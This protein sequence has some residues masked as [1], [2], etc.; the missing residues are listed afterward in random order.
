V[1]RRQIVSPEDILAAEIE[2]ALAVRRERP[3]VLGLCGAQGSG[4]STVAKALTRRFPRAVALSL[5][6]F[7]LTRAERMRLA[8]EVHPL[9]ATR[10]LPGTHDVALAGA[11]LAALDRG[12]AALLPRFDKATDDRADP[13]SWQA[14]PER[15]DLVIFEGWCVG[16]RPQPD[17]KLVRPINQLEKERDPAAIWRR[18]V[19]ARLAGSYQRLFSRI[20]RLALL[21]AP[22]WH[23]V[24]AWRLQQEQ[25]LRSSGAQGQGLMNEDELR[26]F[27]SHYERLTRHILRDMPDWADLV[28]H[29]DRDRRCIGV[30][31]C[32]RRET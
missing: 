29:L 21:R 17:V 25:E 8:R 22:D 11:T 19:N 16:A 15:V 4:K 32:T 10:G 26:S 5:D 12:D 30:D 23:Q 9:F 2:R 31:Y 18:Y 20:D 13:D 14:A 7:Y 6:D 3:L 28:L 24:F 27:I 1:L